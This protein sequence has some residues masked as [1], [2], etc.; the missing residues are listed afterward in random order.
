MRASRPPPN[1]R[2]DNA[3]TPASIAA[4]VAAYFN[5]APPV[6]PASSAVVND[7]LPTI[8]A[9]PTALPYPPPGV[10]I[11]CNRLCAAPPYM[12]LRYGLQSSCR[13]CSRACENACDSRIASSAMM[14]P[15]T[16]SATRYGTANNFGANSTAAPRVSRITV[17]LV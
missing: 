16:W 14:L 10:A 6:S 15:V 5:R 13:A 11:D 9:S 2:A 7:S 17:S 8:A 1:N 4:C 12:R 3:A